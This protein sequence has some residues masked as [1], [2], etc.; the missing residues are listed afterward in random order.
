MVHKKNLMVMAMVENEK[1][2]EVSFITS[3]ASI[4]LGKSF[5][6]DVQQLY[7]CLQHSIAAGRAALH[8]LSRLSLISGFVS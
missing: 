4:C 1:A 3:P 8:D 7:C 6:M 2:S 5:V